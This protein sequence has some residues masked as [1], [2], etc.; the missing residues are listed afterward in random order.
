M[1]P[2]KKKSAI[3]N[4]Q[5]MFAS[6][7]NQSYTYKQIYTANQNNDLL[8]QYF[9]GIAEVAAPILK[10]SDGASQ[11]M[12]DTKHED[13]KKLLTNPNYYQGWNEFFSL[14]VLQKRLFGNA[15]VDS[16]ASI[17]L[18]GGVMPNNLFLFSPQF[19][20]IEVTKEKDFRNN[21]IQNYIFDSKEVDKDALIVDP[22]FILH[23]KEVNPN[24]T[25]NQ[26]LF[27]E[28]RYAG[29]YR[30]IES[31]IEGYGA[32][33]NLYKNGPRLIITGKSQGEFASMSKSEDIEVVQDKMSKYGSGE[34]KFN[35]LITD[36]PL[37]VTQAT[38]NVAQMQILE[39]NSA[40]F[41]RLCDAQAIDSKVFSETSTFT[42]KESAL[43]EFYNNAFRSEIDGIF[44]DLQTYLQ[45]WFP[46]LN[47]LKPN[48][49]QISEIVNSNL[50]ENNR[51]LINA[52]KGLMTR[53]EYLLAIGK[54]ER[55]D[56]NFDK[57]HVYTSGNWVNI[58]PDISSNDT[59]EV[60]GVTQEQL[61]SQANLRGSVGGVQGILAIQAS[62]QSGTTDYSAALATL[63]EI[64][65]FNKETAITI[66]GTPGTNNTD[67]GNETD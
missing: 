28:S 6:F 38:L 15:I 18:V 31:I 22:E 23:L 19:T 37:D 47:D 17:K 46:D 5:Y 64:Y 8:I 41:D 45:R 35:N 44:N 66:L 62:V 12:F 2:F 49:S 13:V 1:W 11:V 3:Y 65:G 34:G 56:I 52:E 9:N 39:N 42:N 25:Q 40:D 36:V 4:S 50:E 57:L 54:E 55:D 30:N 60:G 20:G 63:I 29:C 27:G 32:K 48:Y 43:S 59:L 10:Y 16:D 67:N 24:F 33:V 53:N 21:P 14:L 58:E 7:G 51:L 26:F 61:E